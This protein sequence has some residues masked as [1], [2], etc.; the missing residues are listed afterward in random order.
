VRVALVALLLAA[1][2]CS[3]GNETSAP[4]PSAITAPSASPTGDVARPGRAGVLPVLRGGDPALPGHTILQPG[5]ATAFPLPVVVWGNGG[6]RTTNQEH[7]TFL[8][9]L[10]GL[11]YL[12]VALGAPD[13]PFDADKPEAQVQRPEALLAGID[14]ALQENDRKASPLYERV[15]STR[16]VVMGQSC[17]AAEALSASRD[18]RVT[19]TLAWNNGGDVSGLHAP[20][21]FFSGGPGDETYDATRIAYRDTAGVPAV[22][23]D[24]PAAGHIG[25]WHDPALTSRAVD[26][27]RRWLDATLFADAAARATLVG[28]GCAECVRPDVTVRSKGWD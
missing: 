18:A 20:V 4:Q 28:E 17:G 25:P 26:L 7:T 19:T 9:Q 11:G 14:W 24:D 3:S 21:L 8:T 27:A 6:C 2:A 1:T 5:I 16:I 12:V 22:H 15:D 13:V 23:V 10:A